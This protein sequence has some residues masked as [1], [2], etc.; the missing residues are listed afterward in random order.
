MGLTR[1]GFLGSLFSRPILEGFVS[2]SATIIIIEQRTI[3]SLFS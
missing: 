1:I 3:S 2:A